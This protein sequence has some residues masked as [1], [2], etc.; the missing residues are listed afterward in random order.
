[1]RHAL[2]AVWV[3]FATNYGIY[4]QY[5]AEFLL[6]MAAGMTPLIMMFVWM[7]LAEAG[8]T[9][10][11]GATW[12]AAYFLVVYGVR[13]FN[14]VWVIRKLDELVR[15]GRLSS[16]L[17]HPVNPYW[18]LVGWHLADVAVRAPVVF[19]FVPV[20]LWVSGGYHELSWSHASLFA[21]TVVGGMMV[22][23]HL[24]YLFGLAAFWTDQSLAFEEFY[25]ALFYL[26][27]GLLVPLPMFPDAVRGF[28]ALLPWPYIF[29]FP[30]EV[31]LGARDEAA[32]LEGLMIQAGWIVVLMVAVQ[33]VWRVGLRRYAA[34]GA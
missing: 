21:L 18:R 24:Q 7:S 6:Y 30:T 14:A 19:I 8:A 15:L 5:R 17:M 28:V 34:A 22:H 3:S 29:G 26:L 13:Q 31:L 9:G 27:G 10:G 16:L 1:M 25:L 2:K 11:T 32:L 33:V 23:F 12:F 4:V 20:A